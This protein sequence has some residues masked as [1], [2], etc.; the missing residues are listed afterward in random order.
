[1]SWK[2]KLANFLAKASGIQISPVGK[3]WS[4]IEP[5]QLHHFLDFFQVDCVFDVGANEGQ[6][7]QMLRMASY[8][9]RI[10]SFEPNPASAAI[11]RDKAKHDALWQVL[12]LALD[13]KSQNVDFNVMLDSQFSSLHSPDHS[14]VSGFEQFN[15]VVRKIKIQ[16]VT[17]DSIFNQ[18][19]AEYNFQ[20]PFLKLDTQGHDREIT[21]GASSC[22]SRFVG[23]QSELAFKCLYSESPTY[24]ETLSHYESLGFRLSGLIPNN[25]GHF[26]DLFEA[27]CLMYNS[28]FLLN[29][30]SK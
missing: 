5:E 11:A 21:R 29:P 2:R 9:G 6:Y 8:S 27:D 30:S 19:R 23:L 25:A 18:L 10:I 26:P 7:A 28:A 22:I 3:A 16:T 4:L 20:R 14:N 17:L 1:M 24:Y 15:S 12:E 13:A